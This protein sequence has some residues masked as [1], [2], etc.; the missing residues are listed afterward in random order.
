MSK[1]RKTS[2][3]ST[4]QSR[5][6]RLDY[7][8]LEP[9]Q[10]LATYYVDIA[11]GSNSNNGLALGSAFASIQVAANVAQSGDT[12]L[13][14]EG[15]YRETVTVARSGS[16]ANPI[17]FQ[18]YNGE[19]VVLSGGDL[20]TGWTQQSGDVWTANV[21]WDAGNNRIANTLFVD[22]ELKF[23]ARQW[24][25]NNPLDADDWGA[26]LQG[27]LTSN[28]TSFRADDL[29][30]FPNDYWNGG[31]VKF[32]VNDGDHETRTITDFSG[33]NGR[34]T[35]DS[36]AGI[37][38]LKQTNGYYIY[39]TLNALDQAGEWF[40]ADGSNTLYYHT[41]AGQNPNNLDIEFKRRGY[42]FDV[43]GRDNIHIEGIT[44]RGA[45]INANANTDGNVYAGNTFYAYDKGNFGRFF[46]QGMTTLSATTKSVKLG[47][48]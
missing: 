37:V 32:Q 24:A 46:I 26:L 19:N 47:A 11:G 10:L 29:I 31:K 14:R 12:V 33:N 35:F 45:G 3:I 41:E 16:S 36:P 48:G 39:D 4:R 13:I 18:A 2:S 38:T 9:R 43:R 23:E 27:R 28:G 1:K 30:G 5:S 6:R 40:K 7:Q 42:V 21:N 20:I 15:I 17:K 8:V 22:G 44:F 25:E 34:I